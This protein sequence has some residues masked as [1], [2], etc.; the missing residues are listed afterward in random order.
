ML[1]DSEIESIVDAQDLAI[2]KFLLRLK[3]FLEQANKKDLNTALENGSAEEKGPFGQVKNRKV[4]A[5]DG[6]MSEKGRLIK[7]LKETISLL[8]AKTTKMELAVKVKEEKIRFLSKKL[9]TDHELTE[10]QV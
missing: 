5:L 4:N 10:E 2:E 9:E 7:E 3:K 8:E 6:E 1:T